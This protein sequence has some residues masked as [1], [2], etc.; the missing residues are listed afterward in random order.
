MLFHKSG[1]S[2]ADLVFWSLD[3]TAKCHHQPRFGGKP[4]PYLI[5]C[6]GWRSDPAR[7]S[8]SSSRWQNRQSKDQYVR[9]AR[10]QGL[11][12]RAAFKLLE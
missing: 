12:S 2:L 6:S 3:K 1:G 9:E 8:S 10:V 7:H 5:A 11:K 4:N